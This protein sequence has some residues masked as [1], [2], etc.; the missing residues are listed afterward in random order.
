MNSTNNQIIDISSSDTSQKQKEEIADSSNVQDENSKATN[1]EVT[2]EKTED[3]SPKVDATISSK[4][5]SAKKFSKATDTC[6]TVDIS[7]MDSDLNSGESTQI[8]GEISVSPDYEAD[9]LSNGD[10]WKTITIHLSDN[11]KPEEPISFSSNTRSK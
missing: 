8:R 5:N 3:I 4:G 6:S 11:L 2:T 10:R 9:G 7:T 1:N